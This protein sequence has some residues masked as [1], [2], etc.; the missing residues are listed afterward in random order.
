MKALILSL[1]MLMMSFA[2]QAEDLKKGDPVY[3]VVTDWAYYITHIN[4]NE[5]E[6]YN[7]VEGAPHLLRTRD[8]L[9]KGQKSLG[10]IH[11]GDTVSYFHQGEQMYLTAKVSA[12]FDVGFDGKVF[13]WAKVANKPWLH[14]ST[15][16][17]A[18]LIGVET[19]EYQGVR[20]GDKVC[21][22]EKVQA[23][24]GPVYAGTHGTIRKVYDNGT[25]LVRVGSFFGKKFLIFQYDEILS[26]KALSNCP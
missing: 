3:D 26:L 18:N 4:G 9:V 11:V 1:T 22:P 19:S 7:N 24:A 15:R 20:A 8:Q 10:R 21:I 12:V 14:R 2:T 16:I 5:Y 13:L 6:I 17:G 25:A 23:S